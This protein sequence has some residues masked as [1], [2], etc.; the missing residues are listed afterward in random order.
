MIF[1]QGRFVLLT[2]VGH[3]CL[4]CIQVMINR[5]VWRWKMGIAEEVVWVDHKG[6]HLCS[7]DSG[8]HS[9]HSRLHL[10]LV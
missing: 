1:W 2:R 10:D 8:V 4:V 3:L 7:T 6:G 9:K 5:R